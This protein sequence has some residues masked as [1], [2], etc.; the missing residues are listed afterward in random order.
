[1]IMERR[2]PREHFTRVLIKICEGLDKQFTSLI[3]WKDRYSDRKGVLEVTIISIW[4][5]GSYARGAADCGDLDLV[6]NAI[7]FENGH[8]VSLH[9]RRKIAKQFFKSPADVRFYWG[10]PEKNTSGVA[11]EEA[12]MIWN[13]DKINWQVAIDN[14]SLNPNAGRYFRITDQIPFR[15]EQLNVYIDDVEHLI[16]LQSK[17]IIKWFFL[18]I[19]SE[20][21]SSPKTDDEIELCRIAEYLGTKAVKKI[22]PHLLYLFQKKDH[23]AYETW[24]PTVYNSKLRYGGCD[25]FVG[26]PA[27]PIDLLDEITTF[28]IAIIPNLCRR[29]P[30]GAWFLQRD[31]NHPLCTQFKNIELFCA[32]DEENKP[33]QF[34]QI[35]LDGQEAITLELFKNK[36]QAQAYA[37]WESEVLDKTYTVKKIS[38]NDL[39]QHISFTDI[40]KIDDVD[41]AITLE[42]KLVAELETV[43]S[44]E[45]LIS[46]LT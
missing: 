25:I 30:N 27:L 41:Y 6:I 10:M 2:Y 44:T 1:M 28:E 32:V 4:V 24:Q 19:S 20:M 31:N 13:Q 18:P 29:G 39:L 46:V 7:A 35:D 22:I 3:P 33:S 21:I 37:D 40:L 14:I 34:Y 12:I 38:G 16:S 8:E 23:L 45:E 11:F 43:S 5:A 17:G 9:S 36:K 15:T 26:A 42:G